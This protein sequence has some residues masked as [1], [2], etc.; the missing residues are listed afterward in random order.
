MANCV[1]LIDNDDSILSLWLTEALLNAGNFV[2]LTGPTYKAA[3]WQLR[4]PDHYHHFEVEDLQPHVLM[5]QVLSYTGELDGLLCLRQTANYQA[6]EFLSD[7]KLQS[8]MATNF[9]R[10]ARL[11]RAVL[12]VMRLQGKGRILNVSSTDS[13]LAKAFSSSSVASKFALRGLLESIA[14]EVDSFDVKISNVAIDG[15]HTYHL[16]TAELNEPVHPD[17]QHAFRFQQQ[18]TES[19]SLGGSSKVPEIK[20]IVTDLQALLS[21]NKPPM[22][23]LFGEDAYYLLE[24]HVTNMLD[25]IEYCQSLSAR[26]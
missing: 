11:I 21:C 17:Y 7:A 23:V 22:H 5:A 18:I 2:V 9:F 25:N 3:D 6:F 13:L 10:V 8:L 20:N 1:Y 15:K 26:A 19:A 12:P 4:Y 14:R 16:S 24:S